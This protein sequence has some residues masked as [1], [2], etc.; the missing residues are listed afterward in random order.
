V[1]AIATGYGLDDREVG[2]GVP[3]G[4]SIFPPPRRPNRLWSPL[5]LLSNGNRG[6]LSSRVKRSGRE[7]DH[8]PQTNAEGKKMRIYTSIPPYVI[9]AY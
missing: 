5:S 4:S 1:V 8:S 9:V 3:V 2:V 7:A 6:A